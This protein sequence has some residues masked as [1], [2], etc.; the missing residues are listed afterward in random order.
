M[1]GRRLPARPPVDGT[2]YGLKGK[3]GVSL[4]L[5][6]VDVKV[7]MLDF[8]GEVCLE[9][10]YQN[11]DKEATE[12]VYTFPIPSDATLR[13]FEVHVDDAIIKGQVIIAC[14]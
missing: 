4:P 3:D 11:V 9:Q 14:L 6:K 8:L 7:T 13:H 5:T 1:Y 2:A 12:V 10:S